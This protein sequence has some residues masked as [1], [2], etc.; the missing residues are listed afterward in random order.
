MPQP[1]VII[2]GAGITGLVLAQALKKHSIPFEIYERDPDPLHRGKGWGITIHWALDSLIECLPRH[3]IDRLPEAYVDPEATRNGENG[4]FLFF[5][6]RTGEAL[7]QVPPSKR[8]RMARE[9]FRRLLMDGIEVKWNHTFNNF[10][11][12]GS[13]TKATF[14]TPIGSHTTEGSIIVGCDGSQ[15][16]VRAS[17]FPTP[18]MH[19]NARLPV[20]LLGVSTI[21]PGELAAKVR[22]LD[23]FFFQ[24][25]D[26]LT[27][28]SHWFSFL[29]SPETSGR[30]DDTRE[31]Q[32][33]VSWPYRSGFL[34]E[35]EPLEV[36]ANAR[37][38]VALMK[39]ISSVW[40][41]PFHDIIQNI[42]ED[43][44]PKTIS[45]E[46]WVTPRVQW[47]NVPGSDRVVLVGDAA[48]AMTMYRGEAANHGILDVKELFSLVLPVLETEVFSEERL[49]DA[50]ES[51]TKGM[52]ERAAPA[53][54]HSR[55]ACL[56]AHDYERINDE[57][58][59]IRRR[60]AVHETQPKPEPVMAT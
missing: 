60:I 11:P 52:V 26:P 8:I 42:P 43:A 46:D 23:P 18:A 16:R 39:R 21:Y 6:L 13:A 33:L 12:S 14:T 19:L 25:G 31:C 55:Q 45:L 34:G 28:A 7:W 10:E 38:R 53:V 47:T 44:E 3:I 36:P 54:L 22:A 41:N 1:P 48:H 4:N 30:G 37:D 50:C 20:R 58:P 32:I 59:L 49:R 57:S 27:S 40:A 15:S 24:G 56:D 35:N 29:D 5:N 17:L 2:V 51:Y 9:K